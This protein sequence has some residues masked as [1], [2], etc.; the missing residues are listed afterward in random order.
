MLHE[1]IKNSIKEAML[2]KNADR[3]KALRNMSAAFTNELVAKRR[4]P[5]EMLTNEEAL[6]VISRLVKQRNKSI[7]EFKKGN[8]DDLVKEESIELAILKT[9]LPS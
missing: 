8:R 9:Y 1:Q 7:E 3:L 2:A 6:V 4:K 5:S